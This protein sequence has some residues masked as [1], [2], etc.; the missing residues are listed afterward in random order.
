MTISTKARLATSAP[1][2]F[3]HRRLARPVVQPTARVR[4]V[5]LDLVASSV[6]HDE[7]F[8][9][10][11]TS[12]QSAVRHYV[13]VIAGRSTMTKSPLGWINAIGA[14]ARPMDHGR[15]R[16]S[17]RICD[18]VAET[19]PDAGRRVAKTIVEGVAS[20][21]T[22]PNRGRPGRVEGTREFVFAPLPIV[23]VSEVLEETDIESKA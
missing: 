21:R 6:D 8:L 1:P 3:T 5:A 11:R 7:W 17:E 18:Y 16:R 23:A 2:P 12:A 19:S 15:C 10:A 20:V 14:D 22:F 13:R 4:K 9:P